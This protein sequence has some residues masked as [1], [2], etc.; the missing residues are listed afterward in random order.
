MSFSSEAP[1]APEAPASAAWLTDQ[2]CD[3]DAFRALVERTTDLADYPRARAVEGNVLVYDSEDL[4]E[5]PELVRAF[6]DG[7]GVV[8]FRRAFP[9]LAVVDRLTSV[10]EA[11]INEQR[12]AEAPAGD[13]FAKPGANERVWNALE[14]AALYDPPAFA[15]YYANPVVALVSG[16]WLGPG[17]QIT[18]QVNVVNP[19]GAAQTAHRDYHL[20]FLSAEAVAAYPE[21]VHR[22]SPVLTLQGAVAHCDMPVES[23]PTLYLPYSQRYTPGYLAWHRPEFQ[24]Y[25]KERHVQLPMGKGDAVFFNPAVFHAAGTNRTLDVRRV[26]NLLQVSSAFGRAMET[27]DR[28]AISNAVYPA[29]LQHADD[30]AWVERVIAASA[31]GYAFP[32]NLDRDPPVDGMAPPSQADV[33]RRA[34]AEGWT[35]RALR[36]ALRAGA[37]R[38]ES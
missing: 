22:L 13:H 1:E 15:D 7:P 25:F 28:E 35:T 12:A 24:A 19:G 36:D 6:T 29:L 34:L 30:P 16:A 26:A 17:Y 23:G 33:V 14:K 32:T 10:F 21:H 27:V 9:D 20:G 4:P 8:L 5:G 2:D 31:E 3:L 37:V 38:R 18:S 11:L